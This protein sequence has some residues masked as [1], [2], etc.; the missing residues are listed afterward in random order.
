MR[1]AV[2]DESVIR[3]ISASKLIICDQLSMMSLFVI[4]Y[5]SASKFYFCKFLISKNQKQFFKLQTSELIYK[6]P[7]VGT[8]RP[9][10]LL[11]G[12]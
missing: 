6:M 7:L 12:N 8:W 4:W 3:Y 10:S 9:L 5:I 2:N 11:V 1:P